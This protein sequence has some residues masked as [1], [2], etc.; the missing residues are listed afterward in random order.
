LTFI[1]YFVNKV[2]HTI[3]DG[4]NRSTPLIRDSPKVSS[5]RH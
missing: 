4:L 3:L 1:G 5:P 2:R